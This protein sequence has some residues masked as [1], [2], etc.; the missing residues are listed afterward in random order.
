M[1]P[2]PKAQ[3][4]SDKTDGTGPQEYEEAATRFCSRDNCF[5]Y[6][7]LK[8]CAQCKSVRYCSKECQR[9]D[10]K[11]HKPTCAYNAQQFAAVEGGEPLLQRNLRHWVARFYSTLVSAAIRG[12]DLRFDWDRINQ[13]GIIIGLEPRPHLNVGSRWRVGMV[14]ARPNESI[15]EMLDKVGMM[16]RYRDEVFPGHE[17]ARKRLRESSGG[18]SD[19]AYVVILASNCGPDALEGDHPPTYRFTP[20][21]VHREMVNRMPVE[22][23]T[24]NWR[25]DFTEQ[26]EEDRPTKHLAPGSLTRS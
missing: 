14:A 7:D 13:G 16:E 25:E 20:V 21:D 6:K 5:N 8:E 23:F 15:F 22:F 1:T 26:V 2:H 9:N 3:E 4:A 10:W 17:E 11:L 18:R 24:V 19:Y 12:L